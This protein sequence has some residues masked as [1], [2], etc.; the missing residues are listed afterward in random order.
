MLDGLAREGL[1]S[2]VRA[3]QSLARA[4]RKKGHTQA[5]ALEEL[6]GHGVQATV[7]RSALEEHYQDAVESR[8]LTR[9][10]AALPRLTTRKATLTAARKLM[11]LGFDPDAVASA[12][13]L[14][15][16]T[17]GVDGG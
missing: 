5:R 1:Q 2:D 9:A 11:R 7:A 14:R 3:A 16:V 17:D 12:L 4:C 8:D 13:G 15:D 6:L 10:I